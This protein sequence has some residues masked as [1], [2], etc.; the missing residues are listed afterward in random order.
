M[1]TI[2]L[3]RTNV[4]V[5]AVSLGTWG[6]GGPNVSEGASVGWSGH[7]DRLAKEA[8]KKRIE[9]DPSLLEMLEVTA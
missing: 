8:L 1:R 4:L 7:D 6:H 9:A 3:G 5:P 2:R